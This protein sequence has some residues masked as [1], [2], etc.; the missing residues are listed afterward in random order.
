L[1]KGPGTEV[2]VQFLTLGFDVFTTERSI[3]ELEISIVFS[4]TIRD[5]VFAATREILCEI[6]CE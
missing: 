5:V 6:L 4:M 2:G 1:F 3:K